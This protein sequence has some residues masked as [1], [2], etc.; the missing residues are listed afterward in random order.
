[1]LLAR[2]QT[3]GLRPLREFGRRREVGPPRLAA[4]LV[5]PPLAP[6]TPVSAVPTVTVRPVPPIAVAAFGP[7]ASVGA[8]IRTPAIAPVG[9]VAVGT[10]PPRAARPVVRASTA[11]ALLHDRFERILRWQQFEQIATAPLLL[12]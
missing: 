12:G 2:P 5:I 11:S 10:L 1:M 9:V 6:L 7:I 8:P 4:T 3:L